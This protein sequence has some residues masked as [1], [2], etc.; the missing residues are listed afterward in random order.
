MKLIFFKHTSTILKSKKEDKNR[1]LI[2]I[3]LS[4]QYN[5]KINVYNILCLINIY[6]INS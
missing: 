6:N 3:K 1:F 4:S 2:S 5:N